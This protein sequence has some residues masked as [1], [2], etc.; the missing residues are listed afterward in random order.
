VEG[1][2]ALDRICAAVGIARSALGP[3]LPV[4]V[5]S[6]GNRTLVVP[7]ETALVLEEAS[8]DP[9]RLLAVERE[10]EALIVYL[11]APSPAGGA[12]LRARAFCTG[13]GVPED[14]ATGSAAGPLGIYLA[15]HKALPGG[16]REFVIEQ[17][18]EMGR[19]SEITVEVEGAE[20]AP[21]A[22]RVSGSAVKMM[23]GVV[24]V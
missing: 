24:E 4:Q 22:V 5:V 6:T 11:V 20:G 2:E 15:L 18:G 3:R 17:G 12:R 8:P 16:S 1:E 19:P 13:A 10:H 14:P 7:L 9:R 21:S 23:E